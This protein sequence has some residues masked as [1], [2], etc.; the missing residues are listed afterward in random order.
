MI[1]R[2]QGEPESIHQLFMRTDSN[3]T[4]PTATGRHVGPCTADSPQIHFVYIRR[5]GERAGSWPGLRSSV[6]A[7]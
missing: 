7:E 5:A 3:S 2:H 1:A 4:A 6:P